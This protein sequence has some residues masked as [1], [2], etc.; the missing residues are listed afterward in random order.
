M[1]SQTDSLDHLTSPSASYQNIVTGEVLAP[2]GTVSAR[3]SVVVIPKAAFAVYIDDLSF[4]TFAPSPA[5][6]VSAPPTPPTTATQPPGPSPTSTSSPT[7]PGP[8]PTSAPSPETP[9]PSSTS[10][11]SASPPTS[12]PADTATP[13]PTA[14]PSPS[15]WVEW[16]VTNEVAPGN[17]YQL[18]GCFLVEGGTIDYV[19]LRLAWYPEADGF[20]QSISIVD[21]AGA[22]SNLQEQCSSTAIVS[23]PCQTLSARYG[24]V[25]TGSDIRVTVSRIELA[26]LGPGE[27][28]PAPT[29]T[30]AGSPVTATPSP[31]RVPPPTPRR[32][33]TPPATSVPAS[34]LQPEPEVFPSLTNG[35]F[36]APR[37]DGTPYG[38]RKFGGEMALSRDHRAEGSRALRFSSQTASTKWVYQTVKVRPLGY[39]EFTAFALKFKPEDEVFLRLSWYETYDG[40]GALLASTDSG[41]LAVS[42]SG[43]FLYLMVGAAQA[44]AGARSAK[45]RLMLRPASSEPTA[46]YFDEA[47][48][49]EVPPPTSSATA[50]PTRSPSAPTASPIPTVFPDPTLA[51]SGPASTPSPS[52]GSAEAEPDVFDQLTNAGFEEWRS[53]GG[54]VAWRKF[55]GEMAL[56]RAH[57]VE[58]DLSLA[59]SSRTDS[60]KWVY[61]NVRIRGGASY[62][63]SAYAFHPDSA[64]VYLRLSWYASE[65]GSGQTLGS[66]DST[67]MVAAPNGFWLLRSKPVVAPTEAQSA[68]VRLMFRPP[69]AAHITAYFDAVTLAERSAADAA[70]AVTRG[71][72]PSGGAPVVSG[73]TPGVSA[74]EATTPATMQELVQAG[75]RYASRKQEM[76]GEDESSSDVWPFVLAGGVPL[77]AVLAGLGYDGWRHLAAR[78]KHHL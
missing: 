72:S 58:G 65:D 70:V 47:T 44:P 78:K 41:P 40:S 18:S 62:Q 60:T 63:V 27:G 30:P 14:S 24:V 1:I 43:E 19:A 35:G 61:Q 51:T 42:R 36:E 59:F 48:F 23:A 74:R 52:P 20:G 2:N 56:S 75:G 49:A 54:P 10:M 22:S 46:V 67:E 39:Y 55:G 11:P 6:T 31:T 57:R 53:D 50:A 13:S 77:L 34:T 33:V 68:K 76:A 73:G 66:D 12:P 4:Q 16:R 15:G 7:T 3:V 26:D 32:T 5:P 21:A 71:A 9:G 45:V 29:P 28:C 17:R 8:S 25:A 37:G 69:S 38:W 64:D